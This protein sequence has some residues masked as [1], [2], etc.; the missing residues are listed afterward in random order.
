MKRVNASQLKWIS[1][2]KGKIL[3]D[4]IGKF[5]NLETDFNLICEKLNLTAKLPHLNS[6]THDHYSKYY[7][8]KSRNI[9]EDWFKDDIIMFDYK[10]QNA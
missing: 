8:S 10:F 9:I 4:F 3:V 6:T 7:T 5:E 1:D 2:E